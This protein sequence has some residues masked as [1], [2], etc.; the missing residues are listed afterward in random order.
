MMSSS[1]VH[2][3]QTLRNPLKDK[4]KNVFRGLLLFFFLYYYDHQKLLK[5]NFALKNKLATGFYSSLVQNL[6]PQLFL[7]LLLQLISCNESGERDGTGS[8]FEPVVR[9][10]D[11]GISVCFLRL[12]RPSHS[13]LA[14]RSHAP[15]LSVGWEP[16]ALCGG[17][18]CSAKRKTDERR[19]ENCFSSRRSRVWCY[20]EVTL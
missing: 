3:E 5:Q 1:D 11:W 9:R 17:I 18:G 14:A 19:R 8:Q 13:W 16:D 10:R 20:F 7:L 15:R 6:L 12:T 2:P 4:G